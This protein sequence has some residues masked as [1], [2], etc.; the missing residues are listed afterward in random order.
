MKIVT[1]RP[2]GKTPAGTT[3]EL[4]SDNAAKLIASGAAVAVPDLVEPGA[5]DGVRHRVAQQNEE[6]AVAAATKKSS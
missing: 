4:D 3:L 2:I 1:Q 6:A 5:T